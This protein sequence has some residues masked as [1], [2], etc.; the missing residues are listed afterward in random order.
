MGL[1]RVVLRQ[2]HATGARVTPQGENG[3]AGGALPLFRLVKDRGSIVPPQGSN[4][5]PE[6]SS[7]SENQSSG[8]PCVR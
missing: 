2:S 1:A 7:D 6:G 8:N 5:Q 4:P 3:K